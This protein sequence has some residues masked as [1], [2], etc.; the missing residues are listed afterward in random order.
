MTTSG[1]KPWFIQSYNSNTFAACTGY[2]GKPGTDG[3]VSWLITPAL[4][5]DKMESKTMSFTT[6]VGYT[7][8]GTRRCLP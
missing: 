6:C 7:G 2:N 3:F 5:I 4:D 8:S 1:N